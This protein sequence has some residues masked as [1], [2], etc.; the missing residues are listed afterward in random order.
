MALSLLAFVCSETAIGLGI[1][2]VPEAPGAAAAM[3][4]PAAEAETAAMAGAMATDD[5][6]VPAAL[7]LG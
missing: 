1:A 7:L 6:P 5:M 3:S 4:A 2:S